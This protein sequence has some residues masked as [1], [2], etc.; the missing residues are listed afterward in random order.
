MQN[1]NREQLKQEL[2]GL[3]DQYA[4]LENKY[5]KLKQNYKDTDI[6]DCKEV[7]SSKQKELK[8]NLPE[9]EE[10]YRTLFENSTDPI[11]VIVDS[12]FIDCN[13]ATWKILKCKSKDDVIGKKPWDI[14]PVFQ[15]DGINS[16]EKAIVLLQQAIDKGYN[17]FEWV[18]LKK[19]GEEIWFDI[20]ITHI[21]E[22]GK[23]YIHTV[24]R[25]ITSYKN[26]E[27]AQLES[28][29]RY[30]TLTDVTIEGIFVH[31]NNVII[32][33]NP[34]A[35]KMLRRDAEKLIGE[36]IFNIIQP[37]YHDFVKERIANNIE[38]AYELE[39]IRFDGTTFFAEMEAKYTQIHEK[40]FRVVA[41]RDI[42]NR[43]EVDKALRDSEEKFRFLSSAT[44][45]GIV[46]HKKGI[47]KDVNK[48]FLKMVG[49]TKEEVIENNL[50]SYIPKAVDVARI[51][52]KMLQHYAKPY[53]ITGQRK[54]GSLFTAELEAKNLKFNGEVIR[55]VAMR[56]V[57]ERIKAQQ[58]L[59]ASEQKYKSIVTLA[60]VGFYQSLP[61]GEIITANAS[62]AIMLGYN[63][64]NDLIHK[65]NMHDLYYQNERERL[66]EKFDK[67]GKGKVR[68]I[69]VRF[70]KKDGTPIW[71]L[72]TS[73]AIKN[74]RGETIYYDGFVIDISE[75]KKAEEALKTSEENFRQLAENIDQVFWLTDWKNKKLLYVSPAFEKVFELSTESAYEDR[76]NWS[77][78]IHP[79]DRNRVNEIFRRS[80]IDKTFVEA[81][82]RIMTTSK[83][84]KWILD[85][86]YPIFDET[87]E[88]ARFV[89]I[90]EDIT[91]R[92]NS[93]DAL[94]ESEKNFRQLAESIDQVF[95]LTDWRSKE[96]LYVSPAFKKVYELTTE[97][98]Y[99][100]RMNWAAL[101]HEEDRDRVLKTF[102]E[103]KENKFVEADYRIITK[104][105]KLKWINDRS[106]PLFDETGELERFVSIAEDVTARKNYEEKIEKLL[107][108]KEILLREVH[109][110]IKNNM[111]SLESLIRLHTRIIK[112]PE[113]I[114]ALQDTISRLKSMR[115]LYDKLYKSSDFGVV[116]MKPYLTTLIDEI[117][118]IF[119]NKESVNIERNFTDFE[120]S[121]KITFS[122]GIIINELITNCMKYAFKGRKD[123]KI[124]IS[125]SE[126]NRKA[127][128]IVQDNGI[129]INDLNAQEESPGF[130]LQIV[131]ML[132]EQIEGKLTIEIDEGSRFIID[133]NL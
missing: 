57:T 21:P 22:K 105:G 69:E 109:H 132:I 101:I 91:Q 106:Y 90:A 50:L 33:V 116:T 34:A 18:H 46:I 11:L 54:D 81:E 94:L 2:Q 74:D 20:A 26:N 125:A 10:K 88:L 103:Y 108:E 41:I 96:L 56:D 110:R 118:S 52:K 131:N 27:K 76:M 53:T 123:N 60:P 130:G 121:T 6:S 25:D 115:V 93:E 100:D 9:S 1:L 7:H 133:F 73:Q 29:S 58:A 89:S 28:E 24:W 127:Q 65:V 16:K 35:V 64:P 84:L 14:S 37:K 49:Y 38:D 3:K 5:Q 129:G 92:K 55:I 97:S 112:N 39:A 111:A 12:A 72:L 75:G 47:I 19:D 44:F 99:E 32:D 8:A 42:S 126:K 62:L 120:I 43:K 15:P 87:G 107:K 128:I 17:R 95:W 4:V 114:S 113:A 59:E 66:I 31:D 48:S 40:K 119:P 30:K 77:S 78:L 61:N 86:S 13:E 82:Y 104:S 98:A 45:E 122:L 79:N 102:N 23:S 70:I 71:I 85:R 124:T 117:I 36:N 63:K 83:K 68:N 67:N 51:L 80:A